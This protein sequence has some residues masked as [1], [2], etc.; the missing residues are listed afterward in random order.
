MLWLR[1]E[2]SRVFRIPGPVAGPHCSISYGQG[3]SPAKYPQVW[4]V[5][6]GLG[7]PGQYRPFRRLSA[8]SSALIALRLAFLAM[9]I[10]PSGLSPIN[11]SAQSQLSSLNLTLSDDE[12]QRPT[13]G[14]RTSRIT[15][16]APAVSLQSS[17]RRDSPAGLRTIDDDLD[18]LEKF[19]LQAPELI[20]KLKR[21]ADRSTLSTGGTG[22]K[23]SKTDTQ[24]A[25]RRPTAD[26]AQPIEP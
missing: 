10:S 17:Q 26:R 8:V 15:I 23:S 25:P 9:A 4:A 22:K 7:R 16:A 6:W 11:R 24:S 12:L 18:M 20:Q 5:L 21:R 1:S 19:R 13:K 3:V 2:K 14:T